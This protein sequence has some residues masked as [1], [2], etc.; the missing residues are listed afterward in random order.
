MAN[1]GNNGNIVGNKDNIIKDSNNGN[2]NINTLNIV[3]QQNIGKNL[4][5]RS[6]HNIH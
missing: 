3:N 6:F 5:K 4:L 2:N 1:I